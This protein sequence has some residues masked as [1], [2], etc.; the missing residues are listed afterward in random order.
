MRLN[1]S[2]DF[3]FVP[4]LVG[5]ISDYK[6]LYPSHSYRAMGVN[7]KVH[8]GVFYHS[9]DPLNPQVCVVGCCW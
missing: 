5:R 6:Q 3:V 1:C 7:I 9:L 4:G 8:D 2:I